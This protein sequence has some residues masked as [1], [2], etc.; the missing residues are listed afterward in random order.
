[1]VAAIYRSGPVFS[2]PEIVDRDDFSV[3][4]LHAAGVAQVTAAA[5]VSE[6]NL[7]LPASSAIAAEPC[8]DGE[9]RRSM[10]IAQAET[11]VDESNQAGRV[12]FAQVGCGHRI[13]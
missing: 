10:A 5:V 6:D 12:A 13:E 2:I 3:R 9:R 1:M 8:P 7:A 4:A 11:T